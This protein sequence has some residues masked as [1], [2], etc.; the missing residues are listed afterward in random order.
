[1]G[2]I[3]MLIPIVGADGYIISRALRFNSSDSAYLSR[4]PASASNRKTFTFSTWLKRSKLGVRQFIFEA[5]SAD[6]ATDRFMIRFQANDTLMV[7]VGQA[8]NRQTSQVFRDPGAWANLIVAVDT[9]AST[10]NDRIKIYWNGSQIT[11]FS[12]TSNPSQNANT[13]VNSAA[14]HSIGKTHIDNSH[15]L[16]GELADIQFVDGQALAASE[17]GK[18]N[19]QGVWIPK[20]FNGTYGSLGYRLAFDEVDRKQKLGYDVTQE[21]TLDPKAGMDAITYTGNG[22]TQNIGGLNFEPGLVWVKN[23]DSGTSAHF[24]ADSVRG[25]TKVLQSNSDG[26]ENTRS[27]HILSFNADGFTLGAD[28]TSNYPSGNSFIAWTWRAGGPAVSNTDGT[29][30]SQVSANTDYGFSIVTYTGVT[31][32]ATIGHGLGRTPKFY[33]VKARTNS[34]YTDSWNVYHTSL[35]ESAYIK[36]Q[37]NAAATTGSTI[38]NNTAP[39]STVFHVDASS[40]ANENNT[41]YVA[42]VW[43]EIPGYS[44]ISSYTGN[45]SSTGPVITTGFKVRWLLVKRTDSGTT[46]NWALY[47]SKRDS[48]NPNV[49]RLFPNLTNAESTHSGNAVD[50]LDDGFQ[51]KSTSDGTNANNGNYIYIA[52]AD[53]PG[54]NWDVNNFVTNEGLS[55]SKQNFDVMLYTGNSGTLAVGQPVYSDQTTGGNNTSNMFDGSSSSWNNLTAGNTI[56]FTPSPAIACTQLD[57]WVDTGTPIRVNVNGGGY[58][59]TFTQSGLGYV[60]ITPG[61]GMTSLTS[62]LIDAPSGGGGTGAGIRG[63]RINGTTI[64]VNGSGGPGLKFQ[65]DLVWLKSRSHAYDHYLTDSVRGATKSVRSNTTA[66]E[67]T[68]TQGLTAFNSTGFTVGN[69]G[70]FNNIGRTMVAWCW[71]AGGTAV[72]NSDGSITS[73]V[74]ANPAYGFSIVNHV[75]TNAAGTFGHGLN[76][77]PDLMIFKNREATDNWFVWSRYVDGTPTTGGVLNSTN[78]FFTNGTNELNST[79]PT[80]SV[81]H[82]GGNLATNGNNQNVIT[83]CFHNVPGYQRI[84]SYAGNG[85][86][87]GPVIVTGF[88]PRFLLVR[89]TSGTGG[90]VMLDSERNPANPRTKSFYA[91]VADAEYQ[92]GQNWANFLDNGFQPLATYNDINASGHTYLYWAI[93][94]DEIGADEDVLVDVPS[95]VE[96][97]ADATDT[98]G[99][100][101]RGNYAT[102]NPLVK[103]SGASFSNGNLKVSNS[104]GWH[105]HV[106]TIGV[107]SGKWYYEFEKTSGSYTGVGWRNNATTAGNPSYNANGGGMYLSHNGNKQSSAGSVSYGATWGSG[108]IVG[109]AFDRDAGTIEFYKNGVSQ[110]QAFTGMTDGTFFP[111]V[112]IYQSGGV[113]NFGQMRFKY[114]MPSGYAALNTTALPAA[115]IPDGSKHFDAVLYTGNGGSQSITGLEFS[116]DLIWVK[117]RGSA[118]AHVLQDSVRGF[119]STKLLSSSSTAEENRLTDPTDGAERGYIS[120]TSSTGFNIVDGTS[121]SQVNGSSVN[122]VAWCWNAG[123]NSN[124]TYTVKVVSDSGNKYRFDDHGTSAVTLDLAEGSTYVFDQSDSSNAG[125]PLRFS[126]TANG[127]HGGGSEYTTGVTV[128]GTPGQAGAKTT[129]VV[130]ASAPTLFYYCTQHSGMGGVI[131]TNSTAGSTRLSGSENA[132]AYD[133]SA[134][135]SNVTTLSGGSTASGKPLTNGFDGSLSTATEGDSNNEYA[136]IAI[137]TTVAAGGVR[138]YAAVTSSNPLVINLYNGGSNVETVSQ[139]SSGAK[140]YAT[141]S[142]AGPIT[143]IRI[144]RTGRAFEWN[145]V[146]VNGKILVN[147]NITPPASPSMNSVVKANPEAGFS[148]IKYTGNNSANQ[149]IAHGLNSKPSLIIIKSR[150]NA[151]NWVVIPTFIND[152]HFFYLNDTSDLLTGLTSYYGNHTSS[153]VGITGSS[154]G[155]NSNANG[156][157]YLCYAFAPVAGYSAFGTYTGNGSN[158]GPFVQTNFAPAFLMIKRTNSAGDWIIFDNKRNTHEGN[159]REKVLYPNKTTAEETSANGDTMLFLSNGFKLNNVTFNYWNASGSTYLYAAFA[160][161]P[162]QSNNGMGQ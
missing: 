85:S 30:T 137:S 16:D 149:T 15:Y 9:T 36:L 64:I 44:K 87:T 10:A 121:T 27:S 134:T 26:A 80:D 88:K 91:E 142:Y 116:P 37:S 67:A 94:D 4:T 101:Q 73:S 105:S 47:D 68:L 12:S 60:N 48:I 33:I 57:I 104:T 98:T 150:D 50:F 132:S 6:T 39:T 86:S 155:S 151:R 66:A 61:G 46:D 135:W 22:G 3:Q 1:M 128:T 139:G 34:G 7:T 52:F 53:R 131:N 45:G 77:A 82:V 119:G 157:D 148:I 160:E 62:L 75:G 147:A 146:E 153:V 32:D 127:T 28:G 63:L 152:K 99:G 81:V 124:K 111:E 161:L 55:T 156:E 19:D 42:Y 144:E 141:S 126:T 41:D 96:D 11:D 154:S 49:A 69:E 23:R 102:M 18:Y 71:K 5:G 83:Y 25:G 74:S 136:E 58:G 76:Q 65:P 79:L 120:G 129:I 93:G 20:K 56:T 145:A 138:V 8:T 2:I 89:R 54:N 115:T 118:F 143:K 13:G 43:S 122:Y 133:Q 113:I 100:Y 38:W 162:F 21:V 130:A 84:G 158:D 159:Y 140:W 103:P 51:P 24:L 17:F 123:A 114:P 117:A 31:S 78:A 112:Q 108:D 106:G 125:H 110:G 109:V 70:Q 35:G 107:A 92:P 59:S 29:I 95:V 97:D 90:W 72:S 14:A 40:N